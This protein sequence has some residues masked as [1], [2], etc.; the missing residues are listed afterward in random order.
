MCRIERVDASEESESAPWPSADADLLA[1]DADWWHVAVLGPWRDRWLGYASGYWKAADL[2]AQ[3]VADTGRDQDTL[4]YPFLMC[5]RQYVELELKALIALLGKYHREPVPVM[6]THKIDLLWKKARPLLDRAFPGEEDEEGTHHADRLLRQLQEID[7][8]SEHFRYPV[9]ND[10][11][12]TLP[13]L[14]HVHMRRFNEAMVTLAHY[15]D[16]ADTGLRE[17]IDQRAEYEAEQYDQYG[18]W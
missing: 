2:I 16:A 18:E 10:G 3:H 9:L 13:E 7:P 5:W 14:S 4:I 11:T 6:K 1:F 8:N 15:L 12:D 17:M